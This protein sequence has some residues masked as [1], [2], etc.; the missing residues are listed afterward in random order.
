MQRVHDL[1]DEVE[2]LRRSVVAAPLND[3]HESFELEIQRVRQESASTQRKLES[4]VEQ[5]RSLLR[6]YK[7]KEARQ[8]PNADAWGSEMVEKGTSTDGH[9]ELEAFQSLSSLRIRGLRRP[10][11]PLQC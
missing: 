1:E 4:E 3:M 5:L 6:E 11:P 10:S 8:A 7:E 2:R 9:S